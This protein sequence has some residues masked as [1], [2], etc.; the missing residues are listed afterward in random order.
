MAGLD[1]TNRNEQYFDGA[2]VFTS[3][4]HHFL[5]PAESNTTHAYS[6]YWI[7]VQV[8]PT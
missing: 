7:T 4:Y 1:K 6:D 2:S 5:P 3:L 8:C